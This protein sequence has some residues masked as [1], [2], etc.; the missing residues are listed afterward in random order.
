MNTTA[1]KTYA[2]IVQSVI[3]LTLLGTSSPPL[4]ARV[5]MLIKS[6]T[7]NRLKT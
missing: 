5:S 7:F 2:K 4:P 6:L 1:H 3:D